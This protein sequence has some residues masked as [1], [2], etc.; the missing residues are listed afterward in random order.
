MLEIG[1][2]VLALHVEVLS[3]LLDTARTIGS[4][5]HLRSA[6][7][8]PK[9]LLYL[10]EMLSSFSAQCE[11]IRLLY[12]VDFV[13]YLCQ[14]SENLLISIESLFSRAAHATTFRGVSVLA[15]CEYL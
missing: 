13:L 6:E 9:D 15:G 14:A 2:N 7:A 12:G 11:G 4:Q 8:I 5:V 10:R 3:N 1:T